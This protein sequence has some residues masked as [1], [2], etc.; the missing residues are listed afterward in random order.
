MLLELHGRSYGGGVLDIKVYELKELPVIDVK[1]LNKKEV[2]QLVLKFRR[3]E[4]TIRKSAELE[5]ALDH[6]K[7]ASKKN[8]GLFENE[9]RKELQDAKR[10]QE[11]AQSELDNVVF[12]ILDLSKIERDQIR[13]GLE[14]L[15]EIRRLRSIA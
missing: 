7:S 9:Y 8:T 10:S 15:K 6:V 5:S 12:D 4:A 13:V 14:Q 2:E 3:L 1:L 11:V